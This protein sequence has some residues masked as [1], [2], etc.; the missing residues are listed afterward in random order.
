MLSGWKIF[1]FQSPSTPAQL[2]DEKILSVDAKNIPFQPTLGR[3]S[4][5]SGEIISLFKT[6]SYG[7]KSSWQ[8]KRS[9]RGCKRIVTLEH[10]DVLAKY[11]F[12]KRIDQNFICQTAMLTRMLYIHEFSFN[13]ILMMTMQSIWRSPLAFPVALT[14]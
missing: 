4:R 7:V 5:D 8:K 6:W 13:T 12:S 2:P 14:N 1:R 10:C 9:A 3:R 11:T